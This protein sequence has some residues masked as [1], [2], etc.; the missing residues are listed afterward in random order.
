MS[1]IH[2]DLSTFCPDTPEN[3]REFDRL[4]AQLHTHKPADFDQRLQQRVAKEN[5]Y[6]RSLSANIPGRQPAT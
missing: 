2:Y 3:R 6:L 1:V 5:R 4:K